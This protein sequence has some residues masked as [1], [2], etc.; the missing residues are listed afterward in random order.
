MAHA[1][2]SSTEVQVVRTDGREKIHEPFAGLLT[3][4]SG[5]Y[6]SSGD[7]V[8]VAVAHRDVELSGLSE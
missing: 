1:C 5:N 3:G 8:M 7:T 4:R 6:E 2:V